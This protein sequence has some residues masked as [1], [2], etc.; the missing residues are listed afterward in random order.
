MKNNIEDTNQ[1]TNIN[2]WD[3]FIKIKEFILFIILLKGH[4]IQNTI[5]LIV[6]FALLYV[7]FI[8]KDY[9][10]V[11]ILIT[12]AVI[13]LIILRFIQA[14]NA[15]FLKKYNFRE[16]MEADIALMKKSPIYFLVFIVIVV[17]SIYSIYSLFNSILNIDTSW[18]YG[19]LTWDA[20]N[21]WPATFF[22]ATDYCQD[23][24][25]GWR[26]PTKDELDYAVKGHYIPFKSTHAYWSSTQDENND[27]K[28]SIYVA[29]DDF[30]WANCDSGVK[31][32]YENW[33]D[34]PMYVHCV[35]NR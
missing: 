14:W 25:N 26:V 33:K 2:D 6:V 12:F 11:N 13:L 3:I 30:G 20:E 32:C 7:I 31:S 10:P 22:E 8:S 19:P 15:H 17:T 28:H 35:K 18:P 9:I 4:K 1:S 27:Y 24:W 23:F 34:F 29:N 5:F 21:Y 16:R